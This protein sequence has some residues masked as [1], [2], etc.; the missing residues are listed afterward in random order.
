MGTRD[1]VRDVNLTKKRIELLIF[2][3]PIGLKGYNL[4]TKH[5]FNERL[6]LKKIFGDL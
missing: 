1:M 3:T 6:K 2:P 5:A 4:A